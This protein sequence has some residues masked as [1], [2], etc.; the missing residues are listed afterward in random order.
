[1]AEAKKRLYTKVPV[2]LRNLMADYA[3]Q[4]GDEQYLRL[5]LS[6]PEMLQDDLPKV[7]AGR[8]GDYS[9]QV[10]GDFY[11]RVKQDAKSRGRS[12]AEL[13]RAYIAQ[14]FEWEVVAPAAR[15]PFIILVPANCLPKLLEYARQ[16]HLD[17]TAVIQAGL[18][19]ILDPR[20][21][22]VP[23]KSGEQKRTFNMARLPVD[24]HAALVAAAA[25]RGVPVAAL[26]RSYL[27]ALV[28]PSD[29]EIAA[30]RHAAG[31]SDSAIAR[32]LGVHSSTVGRWIKQAGGSPSP[33]GL[34]R[35]AVRPADAWRDCV[36][37]RQG[38]K[39]R[40]HNT[41]NPALLF[42]RYGHTSGVRT[43]ASGSGR[44]QRGQPRLPRSGRCPIEGHHQS[45]ACIARSTPRPWPADCSHW[46]F[47]RPCGPT[48]CGFP[49]GS[50]PPVR[51]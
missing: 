39:G 36:A 6:K 7:G 17:N 45:R 33:R 11:E 40:G 51:V 49:A 20:L 12:V 30:R 44:R 8:G 5:L 31:E 25:V 13:F 50:D 37:Q 41:P 43:P 42:K 4:H 9:L 21:P 29:A 19:R 28:P 2:G 16:H 3:R 24:V 26:I 46:L 14:L 15:H 38:T 18:P 27:C 48:D 32:D 10:D 1:M 35:R 34:N 22:I 23:W 47:A